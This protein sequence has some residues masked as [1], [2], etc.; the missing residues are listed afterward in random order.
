MG[1]SQEDSSIAMQLPAES[2]NSYITNVYSPDSESLELV[3]R[4]QAGD[5]IA[6]DK[7][8]SLY[9]KRVFRAISWFVPDRAFAEDLYQ[10]TLR[11]ILETIR[12]GRVRDPERL[13]G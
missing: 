8:V 4:I 5:H 7:L 11:L 3:E 2:R 6:E 1:A 10:N 9:S 13:A 12:K